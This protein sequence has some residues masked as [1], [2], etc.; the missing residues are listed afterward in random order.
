MNLN[1]LWI[2]V[3]KELDD[4]L[5]DRRAVMAGLLFALLGPLVLAFALHAMIGFERNA[6]DSPVHVTGAQRAPGL[7]AYLKA[8]GVVLVPT[9]AGAEAVL[10]GDPK[11]IILS[12]PARAPHDLAAG[13]GAKV[14]LWADLSDSQSRRSAQRIEQLASQYAQQ[15]G[16]QQ[17]LADGVSPLRSR[18]LSIELRDTGS[19]GGKAA[20][21]LGMLPIFWLLGVFVGGS[22]VALDATGGERERRSLEALLAQPA[23]AADL[24]CGKWLACALFAYA[25]AAAALLLSAVVLAKLPLYEIG[26]AFSP[27]GA[28]L[29]QLLL[30]LAPLCLLVA[31]L[32]CTL[33]LHADGHKEAQTYLNLLQLAPML[34]ITPQFG[35]SLPPY[36]QLIPM[37]AQER[38]IAALLGGQ[39]LVPGVFALSVAATLC[40][41]VLLAWAGSRRLASERFV[42]GL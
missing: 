29:L 35:G 32:Q 25:T 5:R 24:F 31:A 12:V 8:H 33:C 16:S 20:L 23:S 11:A 34:L 37:L 18:A 13:R 3:L 2:V 39:T 28:L 41:A 7:G 10:A 27:D 17:L 19:Q 22:H 1:Q 30:V 26:F 38:Q 21:V 40:A 14:E 4:A 42:F 15:L 6:A 36:A 9:E